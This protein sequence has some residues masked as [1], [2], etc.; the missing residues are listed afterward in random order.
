MNPANLGQCHRRRGS[1]DERVEVKEEVEAR[2]T[3]GGQGEETRVGGSLG[4][5]SCQP[6]GV[7]CQP[8]GVSCQPAGLSYCPDNQFHHQADLP[9]HQA[10]LPH[11]QADLPHHQADLP[12][13]QAD[14][15]HHQADLPHHQADLPHHQADLPHHQADL[16]YQG[17]K[18]EA[19]FHKPQTSHR[20][21]PRRPISAR[22]KRGRSGSWSGVTESEDELEKMAQALGQA[23]PKIKVTMANHGGGSNY[24][25][26][27]SSVS[28]IGHCNHL[29]DST[30]TDTTTGLFNSEITADTMRRRLKFFFMNPKE[31]WHA[32]R[33]FPWKLLLQ[34][35]KIIVVTVQL[36]LFAEQRFNH[37][38]Y[39][40]DTKISFSHL[41]IKNWDTSREIQVYPPAGGPLAVYK[42]SEF[43]AFLDYAITTYAN[44]QED[45]IGMYEYEY[46]NGSIVPPFFC[47][48]SYISGE[49]FFGNNTYFL[50]NNTTTS[51]INITLSEVTPGWSTKTFLE[52]NNFTLNFDLLLSAT[53]NFV[54]KTIKLRV[55][56]PYET[57]E[58]YR[59]TNK[60]TFNN[61]ERDGQMVV[62]LQ[63]GARLLNCDGSVHVT[64]NSDAVSVWRTVINVVTIAICVTSLTMCIRAIYRAQL[65]KKS[66][67]QFFH[68]HYNRELSFEEKLEFVNLWYVLICIND[69]LIIIGSFL[70]IGLETKL[71]LEEEERSYE[72]Y[73]DTWNICSLFLGLGNLLV[74]FGCLRYLGFFATY[75]VLILT[76]KKCIPNVLRFS[77]CLLMVFAGYALCGWL[78]LGPYHLKFKSFSS[79]MECLYSL[80]NGDDM[81]ATF[82]STSGK[83][84][85]VWWF[86][87][88]YLYTFISL[89]IYVILSLFIAIIMDAYETIKNYYDD[90]FP[91]SDLMKF[92]NECTEEP[93]SGVFH[94]DGERTIH[95]II[96]SFFC[97]DLHRSRQQDG[98]YE[99]LLT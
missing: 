60:M 12:H 53:F 30:T 69:I 33:R 29:D 13:H 79:T 75:N 61:Y 65:L 56:L 85:V 25:S 86:S 77:I 1:R 9:H 24:G 36:C 84:P 71:F 81:F 96:N 90:G 27:A 99:A 3:A 95:D 41:F 83:D 97:C 11:H 39:L 31:K 6:A 91:E 46:Q 48:T 57:P 38:N 73:L 78:V 20:T 14:L 8:A 92:V 62:E 35:I 49:A 42:Q 66:T 34:V 2:V 32:R 74:W 67:I 52:N 63:V 70:K 40:W 58:C 7:S 15:P 94:D 51:C 87:R 68:R 21:M 16:T 26:I 93:T 55:I 18:D 47:T 82:S 10:D 54:L 37:V 5:L 89:F 19:H 59:M 43:F 4:D 45:A 72:G 22:N 80:I 76:L 64:S 23:P 50:N 44:I 28:S 98:E 17:E 88:I